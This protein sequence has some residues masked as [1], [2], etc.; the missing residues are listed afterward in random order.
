MAASALAMGCLATGCDD[1]DQIPHTDTTSANVYTTEANYRSV[2]AKIYSV[3]SLKGSDGGAD[4]TT[5]KGESFMRCYFNLQ[6]VCTDEIVYS[7]L[8]GD[9]L[10]DIHNMTWDAQDAWVADTYYWLYYSITLCNEFIRNSQDLGGFSESDRAKIED[11]VAEARFMRALAYWQVLD[12]YRKGPMVTEEDKVGAYVPDVTDAKGLFTYIES[13]LLDVADRLPSRTEQEY[14]RAARGAAYMLL[15]RLYLNAEVYGQGAKNDEVIKWSQKVIDE[16]YELH[17]NYAE[18]FNADNYKRT[19][20]IIFTI[21]ADSKTTVSWG[22]STYVVCGS[23]TNYATQDPA[24]VGITSG[25]SMWRA[26]SQ[27]VSLFNE[28]SGDVRANFYTDGMSLPVTDTYEQTQGYIYLKWTNLTDAGEA[29]CN[30][31]AYGVDTD[32]PLF[33]ISEAYLNMAEAILRGGQGANDGAD[34][35]LNKVRNRAGISSLSGAT[36]N[37]VYGERSREFVLE[38]MRRTDLIRFGKFLLGDWDC[39]PGAKASKYTYYPIPQTELTANPKL[40]NPEY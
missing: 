5:N 23:A 3:L 35:Y 26:G 30:T 13:E 38:A 7:W 33:R 9:N 29:S 11:Y 37:D 2:L 20:E 40:S 17:D 28:Y 36:L 10:T 18:I 15:S 12:L 8:G 6:E 1:L 19:D 14:G 34:F 27:T 16:G 21:V 39:G 32:F 4:L 22:L 24:S 31:S 25:W